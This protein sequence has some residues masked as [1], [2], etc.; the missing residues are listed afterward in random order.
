MAPVLEDIE[1]CTLPAVSWVIPNGAW[2][3]HGGYD[4]KGPFWAAAIVNAIGGGGNCD[5]P[6]GYW[7]DT[8]I[9]VVW[10]DWGGFYD[11]VLP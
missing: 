4:F 11:H 10:D 9:L 2:S 1:N 3:D 5:N 6:V 7:A 8:V